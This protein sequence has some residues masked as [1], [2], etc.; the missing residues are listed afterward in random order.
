MKKVAILG[1]VTLFGA[2]TF[3]SCKKGENDPGLSL[4]SRT[5][6]LS[7]EWNVT[8]ASMVTTTVSGSNT[9][10]ST[11]TVA[12][13]TVTIEDK[14]NGTVDQTIVMDITTFSMT[15]DKAGTYSRMM[16]VTLKTI[17]GNALP[18]GFAM[19]FKEES[20]GH[21]MFLHKN[22]D[23]DLKK[24]EAIGLSSTMTKN[25]ETMTD[26]GGTDTDT[27]T[28]SMTG[29]DQLETMLIDQLKGKEIIFKG[30]NTKTTGPTGSTTK[31]TYTYE[32]TAEKVK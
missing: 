9:T 15:F 1:L 6:R 27:E 8:S 14:E 10:V 22:K 4:A 16:D 30:E 23:A 7:G 25:T 11:M 18:T 12:G 24:K 31:V 2:A 17:D 19:K 20:T 32:I 26:P 3:T 28:E 13:N 5:A 21:W 29:F